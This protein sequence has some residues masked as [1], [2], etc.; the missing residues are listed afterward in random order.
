MN[1]TAQLPKKITKTQL[2]KAIGFTYYGSERP[3]YQSLY[4][5]VL[6]RAYCEENNIRIGKHKEFDLLETE[7]IYKRLRE[8]G[9]KVESLF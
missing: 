8:L 1:I 3:N 7:R 4:A 2:C 5:R 9:Y 6:T